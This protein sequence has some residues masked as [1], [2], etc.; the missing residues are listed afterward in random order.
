MVGSLGCQCEMVPNY[1]LHLPVPR[2]RVK[3]CRALCRSPGP[4]ALVRRMAPKSTGKLGRNLNGVGNFRV[5]TCHGIGRAIS[6][7]EPDAIAQRLSLG[8]RAVAAASSI[9]ASTLRGMSGRR[10][11]GAGQLGG[12][13]RTCGWALVG[14]CDWRRG[15]IRH[16]HTAGNGKLRGGIGGSMR[17]GPA[18][19]LPSFSLL[20]Q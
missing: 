14:A 7:P 2:P 20:E 6:V 1:K 12:S 18:S 16:K 11:G 8:R 17:W 3:W 4:G 19:G 9:A 5:G 13:Q 15:W 10:W